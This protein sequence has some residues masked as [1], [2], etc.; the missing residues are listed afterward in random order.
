MSAL[1]AWLRRNRDPMRI[2]A[3]AIALNGVRKWL[4]RRSLGL[5]IRS[6]LCLVTGA[7]SGVGAATAVLLAQR[8][9]ATVV[10]VARRH[11]HL[12]E[13]ADRV[14]EAGA[15]AVVLPTDCSDLEQVDNLRD[16]VLKQYG[17]PSLVVHAAGA[18]RW[19]RLTETSAEEA[20]ACM[21]APYKSAM[22]VSRAFLPKML[23]LDRAHISFAQSPAAAS[24][25][26]GATA[27]VAA[28]FALRGLYEALWADLYGTRVVVSQV[29]PPYRR[30]GRP[31]FGE[32]HFWGK[33]GAD[34]FSKTVPPP[35][36]V[37]TKLSLPS[38][39]SVPAH[40]QVYMNEVSGSDYFTGDETGY[41][42]LPFIRLLLGAPSSCETCAE[43]IVAAAEAGAP[44][45]YSNT[46]LH[47][48]LVGQQLLPQ[49]YSLLAA[50]TSSGRYAVCSD[51]D[52]PPR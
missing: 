20:L 48:N 35:H 43:S 9:A 39:S 2:A 33:G 24:A 14:R 13:V 44:D 5:K 25:P 19:R 51:Q 7:S 17:T 36:F 15:V 40:S 38:I 47:L 23:R 8:G 27:Y 46:L 41:S 31:L 22:L 34:L 3:M 49:L 1:V 11:M 42:R 26:A 30:A 50:V 4:R 52:C 18:G 12:D 10:L 6:S 32:D 28:R 16:E 29:E 21:D 37:Y 45:A